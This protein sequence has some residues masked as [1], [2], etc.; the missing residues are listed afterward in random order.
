MATYDEIAGWNRAL[1]D[2]CICNARTCGD[3]GQ[4][5]ESLRWSSVG[6]WFASRKGWFGELCS[7]RLELN[8]LQA[9][10]TLT[11]PMRGQRRQ[12]RPRWLHVFT[13]AYGT[14]G[15]TNL[16]RRWIQYDEQAIHDVALVDQRGIAPANLVE[17]VGKAG[18]TC[19]ILDPL[20]PYL[21]RAQK[22]RNYA[23]ENAD[24][25]VLHIHPEDVIATTAFGVAGGPA[26]LFVNHAD[27][28]FWVGCAVA[29]L[30]LDIRTSGHVWTKEARGVVRATILPL[31]LI[32][33]QDEPDGKA[34]DPQQKRQIRRDLGISEDGIMFLTV[35]SAA[36]YDPIGGHDFI[37]TAVKILQECKDAHL[38]AVGPSDQGRWKEARL[39]TGGRLRAI[40]RQPDSTLF[41]KV[42]DV[43]LE[44]FPAGSLTALLEAGESGLPFVRGLRSC[45][46]PYSSDGI[47]IDEV[48]Q[49]IDPA[50]Y[51][52][53]AVNLAQDSKTRVE[54]G[55]KLQRV[56][57]SNY[58]GTGWLA[59]LQKVK[60][61]MP[62][63]HAVYPD[64]KPTPVDHQRRDWH[65]EYLHAKDRSF[66]KTTLTTDVFV[67]AWRRTNE[68]PQ[69]DTILWEKLNGDKTSDNSNRMPNT[70]TSEPAALKRLNLQ[71]RNQ[72]FRRRYID[73]GSLAVAGGNI[74][75]ARKLTYRLL[76]TQFSC[77]W[78]LAWLKLLAKVNGGYQIRACLRKIARLCR[79]QS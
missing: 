30:V 43:Y 67:E 3:A 49:P 44:G 71:I 31:P 2:A 55:R 6:G 9:A 57:R 22:L 35:G 1:F 14:L 24:V 8:L 38:I 70:K 74:G 16:C 29:D 42:A 34:I 41:C 5:E 18:G 21:E 13:E 28:A 27:H 76:V 48:L 68:M 62:E 10:R 50:D 56:I 15:H 72:G 7:Q 59:Q 47:G 64:F 66:T 60:R 65:I 11:T 40:G 19:L 51:V 25:V 17:A 45:A 69:V 4:F 46:P 78:D 12:S 33:G 54:L 52:R 63:S 36:K 26:V 23:W 61:L 37:Q 77:A 39:A 53:M 32:Q 75:S 20:S 73:R 58:C 79:F